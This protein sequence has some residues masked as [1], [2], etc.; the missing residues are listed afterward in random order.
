MTM[1]RTKAG[2]AGLLLLLGMASP[3]TA[4]FMPG[5]WQHQ[6]RLLEASIPGVPHW[7]V[8]L[9]ASRSARVSCNSHEQ[10]SARPETLLNQDD[11]AVCVARHFAMDGGRLTYETFCT[12]R[13]FPEGLLISSHGTW[14][15]G[16]YSI[17]S[18]ATGTRKGKPVLIRTTSTGTRV[19]GTC[20][21]A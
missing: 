20:T 15:P 5:R 8:R 4:S 10:L 9:V 21:R 12:N 7:L 2:A 6:T 14:T 16:S 3:A 13:R 1:S 17:A 11:G 18:T 19:A